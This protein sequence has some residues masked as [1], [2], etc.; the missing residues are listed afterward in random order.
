MPTV[1]GPVATDL[2]ADPPRFQVLSWLRRP[3][4][5]GHGPVLPV[6]AEA[7]M[8]WSVSYRACSAPTRLSSTGIPSRSPVLIKYLPLPGCLAPGCHESGAD[9]EVTS[10]CSG[11]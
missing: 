8:A 6:I 4:S 11:P 2:V 9:H 5:G 10:S 1:T 3:V 7:R